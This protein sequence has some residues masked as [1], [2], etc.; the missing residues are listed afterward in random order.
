M[1]DQRRVVG[2]IYTVVVAL[3]GAMIATAG[4]FSASE[5]PKNV[6]LI[7]LDGL[8]QDHL[9]AFGYPR[10]T[11][12][13]ID[14]LATNGVSFRN[15]VPT[16]CS[17]QVSLTSLLT[18]QGYAQ[19]PVGEGVTLNDSSVTLAEAFAAA[20]YDTAAFVASPV[21]ASDPRSHRGFAVYE[22]FHDG[23]DYVTAE[24]PVLSAIAYLQ[25]RKSARPFFLYLHLEEP[26]PPWRHGSPWLQGEEPLESFFDAGCTYIP[27]AEELA[28]LGE[29]TKANLIAKYDGALRY[30][31][32]QIG[33]LL[34]ELKTSQALAKTAVAVSTDHGFELV[35]RYSAT[36]G[37]NPF[38]EVVRTF[39]I[40]YDAAADFAGIDPGG[41]QG[42]I[43]DIGPTLMALAHVEKP[44]ATDG[45]DL[46][47]RASAVP[48][49][50][51]ARCYNADVVRSLDYKL[52]DVSFALARRT[53]EHIP[54]GLEEGRY[55]FDLRSDPGETNDVAAS[56]PRIV[57]AMEREKARY[58]LASPER[59]SFPDASTRPTVD[60]LVA[61][62]LRVLGYQP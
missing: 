15:M 8:R 11:T 26:H 18:S 47:S 45:V 44:P 6:V 37:H 27:T 54:V 24:R 38:D 57:E 42:R 21:L 36:H 58:G 2:R 13:N 28:T 25:G 52:I 62:R 29:R 46:L 14:W 39:L 5:P 49:Y 32:E 12:P 40:L 35:E 31:D 23:S 59:P 60:P 1:N 50:A 4:C 53:G 43:F 41:V 51:I 16:G 48:K 19:V 10:Q 30:A 7:T 20:G 61:E 56:H 55:L 22:E 17:T 34:K 9:S 3:A 33:A